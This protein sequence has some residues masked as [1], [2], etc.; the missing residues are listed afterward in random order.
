MP[1]LID[2]PL[3]RP[4]FASHWE[5]WLQPM[6]TKR[7]EKCTFGIC[8]WEGREWQAKEVKRAVVNNSKTGKLLGRSRCNT[9]TSQSGVCFSLC[10]PGA[11]NVRGFI[12][13]RTRFCSDDSR[14]CQMGVG[15]PHRSRRDQGEAD[16]TWKM[17]DNNPTPCLHHFSSLAVFQADGL[18][19]EIDCNYC[20]TSES[21]NS[22][23]REK[24]LGSD[25][26]YSFP[27]NSLPT[28]YREWMAADQR[29][30]AQ[31]VPER[32]RDWA[33]NGSPAQ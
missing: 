6:L 31:R 10:L 22:L 1:G 32:W 19:Q 7:C 27:D 11:N 5:S 30:R 20:K 28:D 33:T 25:S 21:I 9:H 29:S 14:R 13:T 4:P 15:W 8:V 24:G 26:M 23:S 2:V 12:K 3:Q 18:N 16:G 17:F